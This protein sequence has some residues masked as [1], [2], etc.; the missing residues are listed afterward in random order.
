MTL[1]GMLRSIM[2]EMLM[3]SLRYIPILNKPLF[4]VVLSERQGF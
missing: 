3:L 1:P 2:P 4:Q